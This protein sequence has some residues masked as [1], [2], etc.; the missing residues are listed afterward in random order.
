MHLYVKSDIIEYTFKPTTHRKET[1]M[2]IV[3]VVEV[4]SRI[5]GKKDV[6][7]F[8]GLG[9][10]LDGEYAYLKLDLPKVHSDVDHESEGIQYDTRTDHYLMM[11][12]AC[13]P[14]G[15]V[16]RHSDGATDFNLELERS[17]VDEETLTVS[18]LTVYNAVRVG[19]KVTVIPSSAETQ[20]QI[21]QSV[22]RVR[23]KQVKGRVREIIV[24]V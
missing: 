4:S 21:R 1:V 24:C 6:E 9:A 10:K 2:P 12:I 18:P 13:S 8:L 5:D 19:D 11:R 20:A 17:V 14:T 23:L 16:W 15:F 3:T 7:T 22:G